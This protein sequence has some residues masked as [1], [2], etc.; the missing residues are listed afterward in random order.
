MNFE[1]LLNHFIVVHFDNGE[2]VGGILREINKDYLKL[3]YHT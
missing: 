2:Y 3:E 1:K